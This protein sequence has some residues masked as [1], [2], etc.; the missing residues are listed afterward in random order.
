MRILVIGGTGFIGPYVVRRLAG[1]GHSVAVFH[2]GNTQADLPAE[3]IFGGRQD[4]PKI[5]PDAD[6]VIDLILSSGMQAQALMEAFRGVAQRVVAASSIDVYRACGILHGTEEGP[7]EPVPLTENSRLRSKAQTYPPQALKMM[8]KIFGWLDDFYDKIPVERA[9]MA[10]PELPATVLRLPMIYGPGD[11]LHRFHPVLKRIDDGRRVMLLEEGLAAWRAPR[12]YVENVAA[13]LALAATSERAAGRIYNVAETP[14]F[15]ELEWARK[16][17]AAA[18][19]DG[20]FMI[21]PKE[22]APAHLV[23]PGN[24]AQHWEADSTRIRE[25]IGYQETVSLDESIRRTIEWERAHPPG[26]VN[27]HKFDYAA[28]DAA[29]TSTVAARILHSA[30]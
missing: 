13:A 25:E 19:W 29:A 21:L 6:V 20:Q 28:E 1:M 27:F 5:R 18:G 14:A 26:E 4:L 8:Q 9:V 23:M 10:D 30:D 24:L 15:S 22:R 11:H 2:R 16:I 3:H 7:L 17:A 12:G